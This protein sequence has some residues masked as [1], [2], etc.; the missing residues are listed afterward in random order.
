MVR[1]YAKIVVAALKKQGIEC[2][3]QTVYHV[4]KG[5]VRNL[6]VE[7]ELL[8][9]QNT[10]RDLEKEVNRLKQLLHEKNQTTT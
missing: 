5:R 7:R 2:S 1:G 9:L 8:K 10:E 3:E 6:W 4:A